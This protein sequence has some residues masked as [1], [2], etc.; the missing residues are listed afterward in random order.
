MKFEF[1]KSISVRNMNKPK[2]IS[3]LPYPEERLGSLFTARNK[4]I[5]TS[6]INMGPETASCPK[7]SII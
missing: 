5:K 4:Q 1:L 6:T 7:S 3:F 2:I